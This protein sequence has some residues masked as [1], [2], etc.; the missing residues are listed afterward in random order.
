MVEHK[1]CPDCLI[2]KP[3]SEFY[4][5]KNSHNGLNT[6]CKDC[7]KLR[8]RKHYQL[9]RDRYISKASDWQKQNVGAYR[10]INK[11]AQLKHL[12]GLSV[13]DVEGILIDQDWKCAACGSEFMSIPH[14][15][16]DHSCCPGRVSCGKCIR[17]ILCGSCNR[18]LG[19]VRDS[20]P[21]LFCLIAYLRNWEEC[22]AK[23]RS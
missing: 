8:S 13:D 17:G 16:H 22:R 2:D 3:G 23:S 19:L 7:S 14:I 12:Y 5:K 21:I 10:K 11:K 6:Y 20:V 1:L 18:A 4:T 9:N 15:D